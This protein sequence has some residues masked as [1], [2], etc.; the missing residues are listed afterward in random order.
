MYRV[1]DQKKKGLCELERCAERRTPRG[2]E[3]EGREGGKEGA[4]G[5]GGG[6]E[7]GGKRESEIES[8]GS[9]GWSERG[10]KCQADGGDL[11]HVEASAP[12]SGAALAAHEH[13][14]WPQ[15]CAQRLHREAGAEQGRV[16]AYLRRWATRQ[17]DGWP[18]PPH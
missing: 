13:R 15:A 14:L 4:R 2:G 9:G 3:R 10:Q 8:G 6:R 16:W 12:N 1:T 5:G 11:R 7:R 18:P 17:G